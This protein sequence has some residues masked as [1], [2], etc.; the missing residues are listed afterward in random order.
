[1]TVRVVLTI[2]YLY[3]NDNVIPPGSHTKDMEESYMKS[4]RIVRLLAL[5]L[6]L[7]MA[8]PFAMAEEEVI[9][10]EA[11]EEVVAA[12]EEF[13]LD[14]GEAETIAE[15]PAEE[16]VE[17]PAEVTAE[18]PV[19]APAELGE[20]ALEA[21]AEAPAE[22]TV[23]LPGELDEPA[24]L[25]EE[26]DEPVVIAD[27]AVE[28]AELTAVETAPT[29]QAYTTGTLTKNAKWTLNV[30]DTLQLVTAAT[31]KSYKS[32]KKKVATV[33]AAGLVTAKKAGKAKITIQLTKKKKITVTVT[34]KNPFAPTKVALS[35]ASSV[36]YIGMG[37]PQ[38]TA[39]LTPSYA[40]T[41]LKWKSS[42]KKVLKVNAAGVLT[43]VKAGK[44]KITVTTGNKKKAS[45]TINV[46]K[47]I[48]DGLNP[49]PSKALIRS[50]GANWT[51]SVK[52]VERKP[53]GNYVLSF[54]LLN[55]YFVK[56]KYLQNLTL[57]FAIN[58]SVIGV[59]TFP[60]IKVSCGKGKSKVFKV[61]FYAS[62]LYNKSALL[63]PGKS[64]AYDFNKSTVQLYGLVRR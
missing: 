42:N 30:G 50:L 48:L 5:V 47:N 15:E 58:G 28:A 62:E 34:V 13:T 12:E 2:N 41:S 19:E 44:A 18:E 24:E 55:N 22:E 7:M 32:S 17:E 1:M 10:S 54:Y 39:T 43:P 51:F 56:T 59:K 29:P 60:R 23:E 25:P 63:L 35:G 36:L 38:L 40:R 16:P 64:F 21:P 45:V 14:G 27:E 3:N 4:N 8:V 52:S 9:F 53:N 26:V 61:T 37:N 49:K 11:V 46:R 33:T 20:A 31:P 57:A 6:A